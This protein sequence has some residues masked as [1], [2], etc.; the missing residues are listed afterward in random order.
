MRQRSRSLIP[1]RKDNF[2]Q[3]DNKRKHRS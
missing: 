3:L 1:K 2:C